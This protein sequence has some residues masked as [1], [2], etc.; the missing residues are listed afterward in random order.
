MASDSAVTVVAERDAQ[1]M[2]AAV[3]AAAGP[4]GT[5]H[6]LTVASGADADE[7]AE[8]VLGR[9]EASLGERGVRKFAVMAAEGDERRR[10]EARGYR[11]VGGV[12]YLER[13]PAAKA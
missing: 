9:L 11:T 5:V 13:S 7:L 6:R 12:R 3:G 8:V 2:A 1:I 10:F 4:L